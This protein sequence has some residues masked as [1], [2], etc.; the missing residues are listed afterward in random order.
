MTTRV[1][2]PAAL[3]YVLKR[4][5]YSSHSLILDQFPKVGAGRRV[6]DVGCA[7]GYL[8]RALAA[9]DYRVVAIDRPGVTS[10][11]FPANVDFIAANLDDGLPELPD[12]FSHIVCGDIL[13]HLRDPCA[14]L[15]S[16]RSLL[17]PGGLLIASLPNSGHLYFRLNVLTG[18][19]PA[20]DRGLFDRTH[21]HFY[22][23]S[24]WNKLLTAS[25]FRILTLMPTA[26][27]VGLALPRWDGTVAVRLMEE[28]TYALARLWKSLF[29]YQFVVVASARFTSTASPQLESFGVPAGRIKE[30][31]YV[32]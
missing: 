14:L 2:I 10:A 32:S 3:P 8:A 31:R 17:K 29:A 30:Q 1:A 12:D 6:L 11:R 20:H 23:L 19:F 25:G 5:P 4:S 18:R 28:F 26:V 16:L 15:R 13:E 22:T 27:P 9:R 24:G 21:L 7:S